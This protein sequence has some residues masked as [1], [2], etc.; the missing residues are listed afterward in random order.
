MITNLHLKNWRSHGDT[1][2]EFSE[3]TNALIGVMGSG[4]T[5]VLDAICFAL[6][7]TFPALQSKKICLEDIISKKPKEQKEAEV[8]IRFNADGAEWS[9]KRI[10]SRTRATSAELKKAGTLI[11]GPQPSKVTEE[12]ERLLKI[13]YD[14]FT[15]AIYSE[16]N[17][18]DHFLTI[19]KGARMRKIDE[20]LAIDRFEKARASVVALGNRFGTAIADRKALVTGMESDGSI[21]GMPSLARD[22]ENTETEQRKMEAQ[23]IVARDTVER[24]S[25]S[26]IEAHSRQE[27]LQKIAG[28]T[29]AAKAVLK[30]TDIDINELRRTL[31]MEEVESAELTTAQLKEKVAEAMVRENMLRSGREGENAKLDDMRVALGKKS[32]MISFL[33]LEKIPQLESAMKMRDQFKTDLK[34]AGVKKLVEEIQEKSRS[35]DRARTSVQRAE[36]HIEQ[37]KDGMEKLS[38]VDAVCPIC[39]QELSEKKKETIARNRAEQIEKLQS[40]VERGKATAF[41]LT[42][43][44]A[45]LDNQLTATKT[46][47]A[48]LEATAEA[49][50]QLKVARETVENLKRDTSSSETEARMLD[51][52]LKLLEAELESSHGAAER[53]RSALSKREQLTTK[54]IRSQELQQRI[55]ELNDEKAMLKGFSPVEIEMLENERVS[56]ASGA[57]SLATRLEGMGSVLFEKKSRLAELEAKRVR[58]E[59]ARSELVSLTGIHDH[60]D[61]LEGA[62][63]AT[64]GQLRSNFITV[65]NQAMAELWDYLYP[66]KDFSSCRLAIEEG[67]YVLQLAD[68]TGWV[69]ADG[70]ASGG[71]RAMACLALRI[72]F[73]LVLAPQLRWLVL[74]EPTH[75]LDAHAVEELANTL[76]DRIGEFVDQVFLITHDPMLENAVSGHLY[77]FERDKDRD[78]T[79]VA[80]KMS[81]PEN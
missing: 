48:R 73:A 67:D 5:S 23:L 50:P 37:L 11:E 18:L 56:A 32:G 27:A 29:E 63:E 14:L 60:L 17:G 68:S 75:N 20:L 57:S 51:K 49:E 15:R 38:K 81:G 54:L 24:V 12:V 78:G 39:D 59:N 22:I 1:T 46:L 52:A 45:V 47:E 74:D 80:V 2:L 43:E 58:L 7:G 71:E 31:T 44:L 35:I 70:T 30:S 21:A 65:V 77:K 26:L 55:N 28:E 42:E 3:G 61:L 79:T 4:K 6:F 19:P 53:L 62:L 66:Y 64:Q 76:R 13:D 41:K 72:A 16:Q 69:A 34:K 8:E 9:V 33:E 25:R 40:T 36:L 10:I